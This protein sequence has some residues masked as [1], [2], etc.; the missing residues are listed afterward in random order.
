MCSCLS[1][2]GTKEDS[3]TPGKDLSKHAR[4]FHRSKH[5]AQRFEHGRRIV[6]MREEDKLEPSSRQ[7]A[8]ESVYS[9]SR[10]SK[11]DLYRFDQGARD[12]HS[13]DDRSSRTRRSGSGGS[14]LSSDEDRFASRSH[15]HHRHKPVKRKHSHGE[16]HSKRK[17]SGE[18]RSE[19]DHTKH[20][21]HK[22]RKEHKHKESKQI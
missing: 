12:R 6:D 3:P 10:N 7:R 14:D 1:S 15:P 2:P 5:P 22:K 11:H 19:K 16:R 17:H 18:D 21:K 4:P 9:M 13:F 20:R 8:G